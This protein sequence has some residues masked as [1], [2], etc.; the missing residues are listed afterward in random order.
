MPA[1]FPY[2]ALPGRWPGLFLLLTSMLV[3]PLTF[4]DTSSTTNSICNRITGPTGITTASWSDPEHAQIAL[5]NSGLKKT[6]FVTRDGNPLNVYIYR[7][8]SFDPAHGPIWFVMHGIKRNADYYA[9][10]AASVAERHRA[11]II[12]IEFSRRY[13]PASED[14]TLGITTH[15]RTGVQA[16]REKRYLKPDAYLYLEIERVFEAVRLALGG[17]QQGYYLFGHSAGA[18]FT[19]RM[20]TFV[21]CARVLGA[22]AANA[23]WYTL[24]VADNRKK[25]GM[26]YSLRGSPIESL[27]PDALLS[28]PLM[29]LLGTKDTKGPDKDRNVRNTPAAMAQGSHR[30]ARGQHYF[31]TGQSLARKL[32]TSFAWQLFL[33]PGAEHDVQQV[34]ASAGYLLFAPKTEPPCLSSTANESG[35][36]VFNEIM[37]DP[38]ADAMGDANRDGVFHVKD[39]QFIEIVNTGNTSVCLTGWRLEDINQQAVHLFPLGRELASGKALVVFGGGIPTG[40]FGG[41]IIQR[42]TAT[43]G[44]HLNPNGGTLTL[45]D[46]QGKLVRQFSWGNCGGKVC[47]TDHWR[48]HLRLKSSIV[49]WPGAD[50][51][52]R[53]HN[54]VASEAMSPGFKSNGDFW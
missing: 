4:A 34:I 45:R 40:E 36:I 24:P 53:I 7:P 31:K 54:Q 21:P 26:P 5:L 23:G 51:Q 1:L 38:P 3:C 39:E 28:S 27:N 32:H 42:S 41:A 29:L 8:S 33:A 47:S 30:L 13:Y 25:F 12:A 50:S 49:R 44:L 19:H 48:G 43:N 9:Q 16:L 11:L 10:V 17:D 2:F 20:L 6:R 37:A 46:T 15:G 35:G 52:W 18:Q 14:Y 22:I